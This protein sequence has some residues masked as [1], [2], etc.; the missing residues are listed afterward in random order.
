[1]SFKPPGAPT[2]GISLVAGVRGFDG[3]GLPKAPFPIT[4]PL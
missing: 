1:M 3:G 2:F 4:S